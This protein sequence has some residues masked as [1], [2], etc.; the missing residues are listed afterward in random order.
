M[1][2]APV[3]HTHATLS[4]MALQQSVFEF[5]EQTFGAGREDAAWKKLFEELGEV[6]KA[7]REP[8]EWGDVFILLF[9]LASIYGVDVDAAT[10]DKLAVIRD[11][12]WKRTETG[13]FQHEPGAVKT[14]ELPRCNA[15][16]EQ[17][18]WALRGV[19]LVNLEADGTPPKSVR[20]PGMERIPGIYWYSRQ[21]RGLSGMPIHVYYWDHSHEVPF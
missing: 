13:T 12:V 15:V 2:N 1:T 21:D 4:V 6:L 11:R 19:L 10:R 20:P 7:P 18:P 8:G 3:I 9:D 5:A 14:V 17:G 16:F